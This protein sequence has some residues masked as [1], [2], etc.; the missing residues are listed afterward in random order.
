M[1]INPIYQKVQTEIVVGHNFCILCQSGKDSLF[2]Y[3]SQ[4]QIVNDCFQLL[5]TILEI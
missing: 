4:Y 2:P 5:F 1:D 3:I